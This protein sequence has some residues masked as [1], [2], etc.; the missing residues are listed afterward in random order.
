MG[1][2]RRSRGGR[3][4]AA[5]PG[6]EAAIAEAGGRTVGRGGTS[7]SCGAGAASKTARPQRASDGVAVEGSACC[8]GRPGSGR[9]SSNS[10]RCDCSGWVGSETNSKSLVAQGA[11][12][13]NSAGTAL[14]GSCATCG[15]ATGCRTCSLVELVGGVTGFGGSSNGGGGRAVAS[16]GNEER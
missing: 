15:K 12:P 9:C 11:G 2:C 8:P 7:E 4:E 3:E 10:R 1:A 16:L 6:G 5:G 13:L 14:A